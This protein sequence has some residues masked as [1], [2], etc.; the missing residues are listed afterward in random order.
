MI[1]KKGGSLFCCLFITSLIL[2]CAQISGIE[3]S[4]RARLMTRQ[5][6]STVWVGASGDDLWYCRLQLREDGTGL[7]G[8][9]FLTNRVMIYRIDRWRLYEKTPLY[10]SPSDRR[11]TVEQARRTEQWITAAP[12]RL[13]PNADLIRSI[14]GRV[15]GV[16]IH[17]DILGD[18]WRETAKLGQEG[19]LE[20]QANLLKQRMRELAP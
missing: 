6:L 5:E 7:L 20:V 9:L 3:A 10:T 11:E 14:D 8:L 16:A 17:L 19:E 12:T 18:G 2:S 4:K 15:V 1:Q 13:D